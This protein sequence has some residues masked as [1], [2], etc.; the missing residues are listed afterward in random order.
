MTL[1]MHDV[2]LFPAGLHGVLHICTPMFM[3]T[4]SRQSHIVGE[5]TDQLILQDLAALTKQKQFQTNCE[6]TRDCNTTM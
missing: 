2:S 4:H 1:Q 3:L 6:S 5:Y